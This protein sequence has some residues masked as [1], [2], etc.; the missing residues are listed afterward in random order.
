MSYLNE[1]YTQAVKALKELG[2]DCP[3]TEEQITL[4]N[5]QEKDFKKKNAVLVITPEISKDFTFYDLI[6]AFDKKQSVKSYIYKDLWDKY[7]L[8][9]PAKASFILQNQEHNYEPHLHYLGKTLAKQR[10][11]LK[12]NNQMAMDPVEYI[13]LQTIHRMN[14]GKLLDNSTWVRFAGLE[15]KTV[16]GDSV[17]GFAHSDGGRFG[18]DGSYGSGYWFGGVGVSV[19]LDLSP[20]ASSPSFDLN[21]ELKKLMDKAYEDGK[22]QGRSEVVEELKKF[23]NKLEEL[24]DENQRHQSNHQARA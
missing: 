16:D 4:T 13:L 3:F 15:N 8:T 12:K 20:L 11:L 2:L 6:A 14:T 21:A 10:E 19:G 17:V 5:E 7:D 23:V 22:A 9:Q 1:Q 24:T 18:L